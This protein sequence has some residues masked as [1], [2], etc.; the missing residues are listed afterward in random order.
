MT[1]KLRILILS[2]ASL[3]VCVLFFRDT[4]SALPRWLSFDGLQTYGVFHW[5]ILGLCLGWLVLKR[6][7]F[8][9]GLKDF[10]FSLPAALAALLVIL[11]GIFIRSFHETFFLLPLLL[12]VLGLFILLF[13]T[14]WFLPAALT[15]IYAFSLVFPLLTGTAVGE[16]LAIFTASIAA[17][18]LRLF[19]VQVGLTGANLVYTSLNGDAVSVS[20]LAGCSGLATIGAFISIYFLMVLDIGLPLPALLY[21]FILGLAG[22]WLQNIIRVIISVAAG[23]GWGSG[24]LDAVHYNLAYF[25]FP[26]WFALF[27]YFYFRQAGKMPRHTLA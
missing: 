7:R 14:A 4:I 18:A 21:T 12:T 13:S 1:I 10:R 17:G 3:L 20:V 26:L 11:A 8:I 5:G 19:G 9:S 27:A 22:T 2:L 6:N 15:A 16:Q 24:A 25:I 23:L